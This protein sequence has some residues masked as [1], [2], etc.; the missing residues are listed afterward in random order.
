MAAPQQSGRRRITLGLL[1]LASAT[2]ITLDF[3]SFGPLG[4]IQTGAREVI[5]PIRAGGDRIASPITGL[6]EGATD[7][8]D[9]ERENAE[10][11]TEVDR[12]RGELVR[13]G[14]DRSDYEALLAINGLEVPSGYPLLLARVRAGEV[15]NFTSGVIEIDVGTADGVEKDMAVV[16]AAGVVGRVERVDRSSA[17]VRLVSSTEFVMGVEVVGEVGLARGTGSATEIEIAQGIGIRAQVSVGDPVTTTNSDRTL[18]PSNL[19]IGMVSG[20]ERS[21]DASNR[22]VTVEL[23]ANPVD[24]RFVNVVLVEP[25]AE[26]ED[27]PEGIAR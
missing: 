19:V 7:F 20:L 2:L 16:T 13:S 3:Q 23:A 24:L 11:R 5:A 1:F 21:E 10:L 9:L 27:A 12:L 8:D 25:G 14:V 15:G 18:F 6:W 26:I 4:T 17:T 22:N